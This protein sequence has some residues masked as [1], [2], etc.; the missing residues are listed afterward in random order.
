MEYKMEYKIKILQDTPFDQKYT[1]LSIEAF[2]LRY[3]YLIN[4]HNSDNFLVSYLKEGYLVDHLDVDLSKWFEVIEI[5]KSFKVGDWVW[6][7]EEQKAFVAT[8]YSKS[9][10]TVDWLPNCASIEAINKHTHLYKR[11]ATKEEIS[12]YK[13]TSFC[14]GK[15]LIGEYKCYYYHNIWKDL[16]GIH[17][18][19]TK[20]LQ[21]ERMYTHISILEPATSNI[22]S[23]WSCVPNGLKVGCIE[24][25]HNDIISIAKILK[26][27]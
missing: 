16:I 27:I 17:K 20:Y 7:E 11:L 12:Y 6:H 13:L 26:L 19:I 2:R 24:I 10:F 4:T 25:S 3:S 1:V 21:L 15:V 22:Q 23:S 8:S 5:G 18:N 14:K 9:A